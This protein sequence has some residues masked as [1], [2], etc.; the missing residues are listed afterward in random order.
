LL[1]FTNNIARKTNNAVPGLSLALAG[2]SH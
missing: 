1:E 2:T